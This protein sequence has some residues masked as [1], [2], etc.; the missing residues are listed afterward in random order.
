MMLSGN[1]ILTICPRIEFSLNICGFFTFNIPTIILL[2]LSII[3]IVMDLF[4]LVLFTLLLDLLSL[5]GTV[6]CKKRESLGV[7]IMG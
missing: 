5:G 6:Q 4:K 3:R 2:F 1:C 7:P